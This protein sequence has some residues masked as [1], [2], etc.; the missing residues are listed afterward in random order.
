MC[1]IFYIPFFIPFVSGLLWWRMMRF[2]Q[3]APKPLW[4]KDWVSRF[5]ILKRPIGR[6]SATRSCFVYVSWMFVQNLGLGNYLNSTI[7][8]SLVEACLHDSRWVNGLHITNVKW[9]DPTQCRAGANLL[10]EWLSWVVSRICLRYLCPSIVAS[11][12]WM[13]I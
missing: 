10:Q 9:C 2:I 12:W 6:L 5:E 8:Y 11:L 1:L 7:G 3:N 4:Q 13:K